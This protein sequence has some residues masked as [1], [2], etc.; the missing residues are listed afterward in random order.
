MSKRIFFKS[1]LSIIVLAFILQIETFNTI[2]D[3]KL[4]ISILGGL[5][6]G[7]GLGITIRN[8]AVLDGSEILGVF[9]NDRFGI[10]IGKV[11]LGFNVIL[12]GITAMILPIEVALYSILTFIITAQVTDTVIRGFENFIGVMIVS[13]A[14]EELKIAILEQLGDGLTIYKGESGYGHKG[15]MKD[16]RIFHTI[17]NRI[18]IR[19]LNKIIE[20]VDPHAFVVEYDVNNIKGGV[21]RKYL[22]RNKRNLQKNVL[23]VNKVDK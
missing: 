16:M 8:G 1:I 20:S 18:D 12:F 19:K 13:R 22:E 5:F 10:E 4:L 17:V 2:T 11:I 23:G 6:V 7:L 21:L 3:D 14:D 9:I 15:E